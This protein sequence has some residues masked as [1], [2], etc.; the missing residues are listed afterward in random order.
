MAASPHEHGR[1]PL[2]R[3]A[4]ASVLTGSGAG[5]SGGHWA[6]PTGPAPA[7]TLQGLPR[8][9]RSVRGKWPRRKGPSTPQTGAAPPD[10]DGGTA[11]AARVTPRHPPMPPA[12]PS[13]P[14]TGRPLWEG[15]HGDTW[16][17]VCAP[18]GV[19]LTP[20]SPPCEGC[21]DRGGGPCTP[22]DFARHAAWSRP[23]GLSAWPALRLPGAGRPHP[24]DHALGTVSTLSP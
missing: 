4:C 5:R 1:V 22:P 3:L 16:V 2:L 14:D 19:T 21:Q 12:H 8:C 18:S 24:R 10:P 13:L 11:G 23:S 7:A 9:P 17:A 6:G 20:N 15:T